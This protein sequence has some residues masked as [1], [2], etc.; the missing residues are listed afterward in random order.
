MASTAATTSAAA[1]ARAAGAADDNSIT[2]YSPTVSVES[3]EP[4]DSQLEEKTAP[5]PLSVPYGTRNVITNKL[6]YQGMKMA[7]FAGER[8]RGRFYTRKTFES[9]EV[10]KRNPFDRATIKEVL[11]YTASIAP[12]AGHGGRYSRRG[13]GRGSRRSLGRGSGRRRSCRR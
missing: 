6:I 8:D 5:A 12:K 11:Y 13:R 4:P 2:T 9:L 7:N 1:S 3:W 10:P